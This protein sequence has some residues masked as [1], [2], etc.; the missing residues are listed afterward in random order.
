MTVASPRPR[1]FEGDDIDDGNEDEITRRQPL[2]FQ[3]Y[4]QQ[5]IAVRRALHLCRAY[6]SQQRN[7]TTPVT[8]CGR[9]HNAVSSGRRTICESATWLPPVLGNMRIGELEQL[10]QWLTAQIRNGGVSP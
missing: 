3:T 9:A 4:G 8:A 6:P 7:S 5:L 1:P 10:E 2:P